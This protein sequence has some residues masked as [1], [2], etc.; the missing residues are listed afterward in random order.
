MT[1]TDNQKRLIS[2]SFRA[3][4]PI[5]GTAAGLFYCRLFEIDPG[6]RPLFRGNIEDQGRKLMQTLG[7]AVA[8]LD[9]L[10]QLLPALREMGRRHA[11]YGVAEPHYET[12]GA[13][14]L[15]T[16]GQGLADAFTPDVRQAWAALYGLLA[17][18]MKLGAAEP[19][20]AATA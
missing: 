17:T 16:L 11:G 3:V 14:L 20:M 6:V 18:E 2:E 7:Y 5:A 19:A 1:L 15:W 10:E 9:R 4:A 13:A 12:V 8:S